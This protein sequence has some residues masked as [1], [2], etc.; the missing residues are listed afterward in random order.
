MV[1]FN[2]SAAKNNFSTAISKLFRGKHQ[3]FRRE[4]PFFRRKYIIPRKR[5]RFFRRGRGKVQKKWMAPVGNHPPI[6][7]KTEKIRPLYATF[8]ILFKRF[9]NETRSSSSEILIS[10][11]SLRTL[12]I[13]LQLKAFSLPL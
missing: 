4:A 3:L 8:I 6:F 2:F 5:C 9:S 11:R 7:H 10:S 12:Q 13:V 1:D